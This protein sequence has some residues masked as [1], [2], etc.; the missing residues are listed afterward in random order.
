MKDGTF[1]LLARAAADRVLLQDLAANRPAIEQRAAFDERW[2][3]E[4]ILMT[5]RERMAGSS[6]PF[7][8]TWFIPAI[9]RY[10]SPLGEVLV[11]SLFLQFFAL[12][13]PLFFQVVVDKVLVHRG[14]STLDVLMIGLVV[15][16]VFEVTCSVACAPTC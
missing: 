9:V 5:T 10:R 14:L 7:D 13:T 8:F 16:S 12:M 11:A 2:S 4:L 3:G 6:R 15:I 1:A